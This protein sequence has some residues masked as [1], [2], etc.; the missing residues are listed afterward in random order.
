MRVL[1]NIGIDRSILLKCVRI[2]TNDYCKYCTELTV[3][4]KNA[5]FL[6]S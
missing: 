2:R 6:S 1:K 4:L 5:D 3:F